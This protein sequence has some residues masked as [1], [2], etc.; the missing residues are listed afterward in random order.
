MNS[1][2]SSP[3]RDMN[4]LIE[5]VLYHVRGPQL[6]DDS[7]REE[8][9]KFCMYIDR[10]ELGTL[11]VPWMVFGFAQ[12]S[13]LY[14]V[15]VPERGLQ[16]TGDGE[17]VDSLAGVYT[18]PILPGMKHKPKVQAFLEKWQSLVEQRFLGD[19]QL[20]QGFEGVA[21]DLGQLTEVESQIRDLELRRDDLRRLRRDYDA[22]YRIETSMALMK[23][24]LQAP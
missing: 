15:R 9:Y 19:K 8:E 22:G 17:F 16:I 18:I 24:G 12:S 23:L 14:R 1:Q 7:G 2:A 13:S 4:V 20:G 10:E 5:G 6:K 3:I 21:R 11:H